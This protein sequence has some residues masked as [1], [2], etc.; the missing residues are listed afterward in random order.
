MRGAGREPGPTGAV[1]DRLAVDD[2]EGLLEDRMVAP[3]LLPRAQQVVRAIDLLDGAGQLLVPVHDPEGRAHLE[4]DPL[5]LFVE[6]VLLLQGAVLEIPA[7]EVRASTRLPASGVD[8]SDVLRTPGYLVEA[9]LEELLVVEQA[10]LLQ[11][12]AV[13]RP[14]P[15]RAV[16]EAV[17]IPA[18][19]ALGAALGVE[20]LLRAV[21]LPV[22]PPALGDEGAVA[23]MAADG[24]V[25][26]AVRLRGPG[27]GARLAEPRR[28]GALPDIAGAVAVDVGEGVTTP[29][30]LHPRGILGLG[31]A[32]RLGSPSRSPERLIRRSQHLGQQI[33][34][35]GLVAIGACGFE[36]VVAIH[37]GD[38]VSV[39][40]ELAVGLALAE[41]AVEGVPRQVSV[42]PVDQVDLRG[43][44][45]VLLAHPE[46]LQLCDQGPVQGVDAVGS[47][48][49]VGVGD[50]V[51]S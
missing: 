17:A 20:G 4:P 39:L 37:Q 42:G 15:V 30:V 48:A 23:G 8:R 19:L 7:A 9:P 5:T 47:S 28:A 22:L 14:A 38:Q 13:L 10:A 26:G 36:A 21:A 25:A 45:A 1:E 35:G 51:L 6:A 27:D 34:R 41:R 12:Q 11:Q 29:S 46:V 31:V 16:A 24:A 2:H 43:D 40:G 18:L 33:L 3:A 50:E 32:G 49:A 44:V